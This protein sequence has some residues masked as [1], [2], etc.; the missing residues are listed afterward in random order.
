MRK[1]N[2]SLSHT[3]RPLSYLTI[4]RLRARAAPSFYRGCSNGAPSFIRIEFAFAARVLR[5]LSRQKGPHI[6]SA[7]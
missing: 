6:P 3:P 5:G 2:W 1:H 7:F 4:H